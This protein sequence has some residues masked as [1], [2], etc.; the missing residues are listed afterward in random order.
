MTGRPSLRVSQVRSWPICA[1]ANSTYA[2]LQELYIQDAPVI[3]MVQTPLPVAMRNNVSG[4]VQLP[5]GNQVFREARF[6]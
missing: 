4:F 6:E 5:L 3:F 2:E 1:S